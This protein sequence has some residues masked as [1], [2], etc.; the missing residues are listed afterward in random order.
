MASETMQQLVIPFALRKHLMRGLTIEE[1]AHQLVHAVS[2]KD[3]DEIPDTL[4]IVFGK[5]EGAMAIGASGLLCQVAGPVYRLLSCIDD[6]ALRM[7]AAQWLILDPL[8][9]LEPMAE[10][11]PEDLGVVIATLQSKDERA[12]ENRGAIRDC[13]TAAVINFYSLNFDLLT[14]LGQS[15]ADR[16]GPDESGLVLLDCLKMRAA[17]HQNFWQNCELAQQISRGQPAVAAKVLESYS[18]AAADHT[19][20]LLDFVISVSQA[21]AQEMDALLAQPAAPAMTA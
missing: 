15:I 4:Q 3:D 20:N 10:F 19:G 12:D 8:V 9:M 14:D 5:T 17:L 21:P 6:S 13:I 7:Q 1:F 16:L 11:S 18:A 2:L